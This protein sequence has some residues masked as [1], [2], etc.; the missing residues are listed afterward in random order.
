MKAKRRG[1]RSF[2]LTG[3][4]AAEAHFFQANRHLENG[5]LAQAEASYRKA[6]QIFPDFAEAHA[7]LGLLLDSAAA[8]ACFRRSLALAPYAQ[9]C[10]NLGALLADQKRFVEALAAYT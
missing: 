3:R 10:L 7:N 4:K 6:L 8:E 5:A 2:K 1:A 9:T